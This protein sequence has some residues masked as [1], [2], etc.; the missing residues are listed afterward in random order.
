MHSLRSFSM[1]AAV[2]AMAIAVAPA[3]LAGPNGT[4]LSNNIKD[5]DNST[6]QD[7]T[8]GSGVKTPHLQNGAVTSLKLAAGAVDPTALATAAVT[9]AKL[10]SSSVTTT[11]IA[12]GAVTAAKL[13]PAAVGTAAI[14]DGAVTDAKITGP[15]S[16]S[17]LGAHTHVTADVTGLDAALAAKA[18]RYASVVVVSLDGNGDYSDLATAL[19]AVYYSQS[20][21]LVKLLPGTYEA[22]D[23]LQLGQYVTLEGSGEDTTW[24]NLSSDG[25]R[26]YGMMLDAGAQ[27][28]RLSIN[29]VNI[30][31]T[32]YLG[33]GTKSL[34]LEHV[35]VVVGWTRPTP[36]SVIA[37]GNIDNQSR[38]IDVDH[39]T[40]EMNGAAPNTAFSMATAFESVP[41]SPGFLRI[42]DSSFQISGAQIGIGIANTVLDMD[43][44]DVTVSAGWGLIADLGSTIRNSHISGAAQL[45]NSTVSFSELNGG[46]SGTGASL[47]Y[48]GVSSSI[49]PGVAKCIGVYDAN[50][51]PV[52]CQ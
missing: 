17:K 50:L 5:A 9:S 39:V 41:T 20:P 48:T 18:N 37:I 29:S 16:G 34:R 13:A 31:T 7:S 8:K 1:R 43:R 6:G 45:S 40:V 10:A 44:T 12:T 38:T 47:V 33:A 36:D 14:A 11:A 28:R 22:P 49:A 21:V 19:N 30:V 2:A 46:V 35:T 23:I 27:L 52:T 3:A 42:R 25:W 51:A 15:I 32:L 24:V 26:N 4:V